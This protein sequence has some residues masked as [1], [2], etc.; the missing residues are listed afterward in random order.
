MPTVLVLSNY[1]LLSPENKQKLIGIG[2]KALEGSKQL[3]E[4]AHEKIMKIQ[5]AKDSAVLLEN[6]ASDESESQITLVCAACSTIATEGSVFCNH[7]GVK[8]A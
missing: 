8:I 2:I 4:A 3:A 1:E 6:V 5:E 7:C